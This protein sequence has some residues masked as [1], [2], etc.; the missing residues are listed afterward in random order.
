MNKFVKALVFTAGAVVGGAIV[1]LSQ[2]ERIIDSADSVL[3]NAQMCFDDYCKVFKGRGCDFKDCCQDEDCKFGDVQACTS[4]NDI[5][6]RI[7]QLKDVTKCT[8]RNTKEEIEEI[9]N[10]TRYNNAETDEN[11]MC[12]S[13]DSNEDADSDTMELLSKISNEV[14]EKF[15][16]I[17]DKL[18][19]THSITVTIGVNPECGIDIDISTDDK[20]NESD[21]DSDELE[22][23]ST[24]E[25]NA[26]EESGAYDESN[27]P[28][29][30][31]SDIFEG[32]TQKAEDTNKEDTNKEED[33]PE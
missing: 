6:N 26:I 9:Y 10:G 8:L 15:E 5:I 1:K 25:E 14:R 32:D 20:D 16:S 22:D 31:K 19:G 28:D 11:D 27:I 2:D 3:A 21:A 4:E 7:R 12:D 17:K 18:K 24:E 33:K 23:I 13:L 29:A 30:S